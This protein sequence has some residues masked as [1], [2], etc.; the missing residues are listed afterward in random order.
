MENET[1]LSEIEKAKIYLNGLI[2]SHE[3]EILEIQENYSAT[4]IKDFFYSEH[5]G[6]WVMQFKKGED[7][8]FDTKDDLMKWIAAENADE[9]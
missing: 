6:T 8:E 9:S 1:G 7:M 2:E 5:R 3:Q 4:N